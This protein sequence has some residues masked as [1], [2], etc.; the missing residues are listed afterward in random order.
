[1]AIIKKFT[2]Y[3]NLSN[4]QVL[5]DD[6]NPNSDYFR[7]TEFRETFTGGKNAFLIEGSPL[8]K[9]TTEIKIE[10]LDVEGNP[11][12]YEPGDG[13]PE[14]YE[15]L[16]KV[17][18]VHIYPDTPIGLGKITILGELKQYV[19]ELGIIRD[20][21]DEWKGAYNVK[22][23][24]N[25][26][27]NR[28]LQNESAVRFY[29]RP[30]VQ[31]TEI[32]KPIFNKT[33]P[34]K[35][36]SGSVSGEPIQPGIGTNISTWRAGT[37]YR[38]TLSSGSWDKDIDENPINISVNGNSFNPTIIEVLNDRQVL[39]DTPYS[40]N[41]LVQ[42]FSSQSFT[43]SYQDFENEIPGE[44]SLTGSFGKIDLTQ[45][46]TFAGDVARVKI[47]RRSRNEVGDFQFVQESRLE[48]TEL[49]RDIFVSDAVEIP[50]GNFSL[51]ALNTYWESSS[52]S[53]PITVDSS[54]L[55][56]AVKVDYA[57]SGVQRLF[58][59]QSFNI[60]KDV[61]YE[62]SFKTL[63][64]GSTT[65]D[66]YLRAYLTGS[67]VNSNS[68]ISQFEQNF[69]FISGSGVFSTRQ[70]VS[71]NILAERDITA[72]L[73]FEFKGDDWYL[74]Q[75]SLK[76][77]QE[78]SFSPDEFTLIQ[79]I[80]RKL[81][82]ETFDFRFEF[83][84]I[85]NNY[86]PVDVTATKEFDGGND[87]IIGGTSARI[88]T[89]E[90]DRNAF[91]YASG[92]ASPNNQT[93]LLQ[94]T[95]TNLTGSI[96]YESSA[97]DQG[98][99][100]L[101]SSGWEQ[102]PGLLTNRT[103]S[104]SGG[105]ST[106]TVA[107]FS[108]SWTG[109]GT[110]PEVYS[111]VYT[112]SVEDLQ[113]FETVFR[114]E[115]GDN[116][117]QLLVTSNANQFIY[118]PTT[119]SPKPSGQSI[120][121]RAQRKNLESLNSTITVTS[122]SNLPPLTV[123]SD[124]GGIKTYSISALEFS[125][126]FAQN[127][128]DEVTYNFSSNDVFGVAQTDE[129][130]ISKVI[131]FDGISVV[132]STENT[133]FNADSTGTVTSAELDTGD[134]TVD[135]RVGSNVISHSEGLG[136]KNTFDIVSVTPSSGL[137]AN[138]TSPITN[139]YGISAMGVD[140]GTLTLLIR[141]K[142]GDNSTTVDFTKVVNYSKA[143]KAQPS[144]T[145]SATP[146]AQTISANS[147]G[148]LIGAITDVVISG[149]EGSTSLTYNQSPTLS[150]GQYKITNVTG[151]NVSDTTPSSSTIDITAFSGDTATGTASIS[152][153]DSEGTSGT[154][155]IK[156][157]LS[158]AKRATPVIVASLNPQTQT[159]D[160]NASFSSVGTPQN[161]TLIVNEGGTNYTYTTGTV[162]ENKFKI[163][164]VTGGTNNN[165]GTITPT[166]PTDA[167]GTS[168]TITYSYTNSEG[169]PF[170]SKTIDFNVGVSV[171]GINGTSGLSAFSIEVNPPSQEVIIDIQNNITTPDT[172]SV[173]VFDAGGIYTYSELPVSASFNVTNLSQ[174]NHSGTPSNLSGTITPVVPDDVNGSEVTFDVTVTDRAGVTSDAISKTHKIRVVADGSTGPGIVFTGVW[175]TDRIYQYDISNGR[176][177]AVLWSTNGN[178]PYETYYATLQQAPADI[179]S[180]DI[181]TGSYWEY[182][183]E[184]DFFVA[185]KIA[186]FEES[187]IKN[188][189]NIGANNN[190]ALSSA[191]I[192]L[193]GKD[194]YPYFSLGQ[195]ATVG[196]QEYGVNGIFIGRHDINKNINAP[197]GSY[198]LSLVNGTSSWLKWNGSSLD[199]KGDITITNPDDF[200]PTDAEA[201]PSDYA[202]GGS[203]F[204]LRSETAATGLNLNANYLGY[205][206][207]TQFKSYMDSSGN[208]YLSGTNQ[209][210]SWDAGTDT[211]TINGEINITN[212]DD[213]APT[214]A[215]ANPS[216]Y[217]F[218][219]TGF[220]LRSE[221][222]AV[223]LN[224]NANFL[225]YHN[226]TA[227]KS[228]MDSSGN[229]YLSG[230]N[231]G[232]SWNSATD[233]LNINGSITFANSPNISTFTNDSGF[234]DDT[235]AN[236]AQTAANNA[237]TA[238]SNAQ[239]TANN[240][241]IAASN[242]QTT[243]NSRPKVF[244]QN[245][246]PSTSEPGGSLWYDTDDG[247]KLYI[248]VGTTWTVTQDG[249][250]ASAISAAS[251]ASIAAGAVS[252]DLQDVID[253]VSLS[254]AGTFIDAKT[255]FAPLIAGTT[256][257]ISGTFKVGNGGITLDGPNKKIFTGTGTWGN[258]NTPFYVDN[259]SNFSLGT[260]I[261][262][263]GTTLVV[264]GE[265]N[266][267]TGNIGGWTISPTEISGG[268]LEL[269]S[270][271]QI[272]VIDS[273]LPKL[274]I[275]SGPLSN[276][277]GGSSLSGLNFGVTDLFSWNDST[278]SAFT[279]IKWGGLYDA[280]TAPAAGTYAGTVS[281]LAA[282][283][284]FYTP[285][286][287][288]GFVTVSLVAQIASNTT[289]TN[290]IS[291]QEIS[292][293]TV[294]TA[295]TYG[296]LPAATRGMLVNIPSSGTYYARIYW[297]R[298]VSAGFGGSPVGFSQVFSVTSNNTFATSIQASELTNEGL[299][300]VASAAYY[301]RVE[302]DEGF[303]GTTPFVQVGGDL[304]A[305]GNI[306]AYYSS[307]KRLKDNITPITNPLSK[308][309][310]L[311]GYEFDWNNNHPMFK[312]THDVGVIAQEVQDIHPEIVGD[313]VGGYLGVKYEKLV[314]LL[315][316]GIKELSSKVEF[317]EN[318][319][320]ELKDGNK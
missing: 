83:Y 224:L 314:P 195:S 10:I 65:S 44:S 312:G 41:S 146:Q 217:A 71:Q 60:S 107:N 38:L 285:S 28:N 136:S 163:T 180:P 52:I 159:V 203:G 164:S 25:F 86:I 212:P 293:V 192:T 219:G 150:P 4:Y 116:A 155:T 173:Q 258:S 120:T 227:F 225:G 261:T 132:L 280:F 105:S 249:Q 286:G 281:C 298:S 201:N 189:L 7:I 127:N 307:D 210:L 282:P 260:G 54:V 171:Q 91:R 313:M 126:S 181:T 268:D 26:Q 213:F 143:K 151:V 104:I 289:F 238:A 292:T 222:A 22:W 316:E 27:I 207:G 157:T 31:I 87:Y 300:V 80:P 259:A 193:W 262:W 37:L 96:L 232:L 279:Q 130:T 108:G 175:D 119:L 271:G 244:R 140:S 92:S 184:E 94:V 133:S 263:N 187:F 220:A 20:V 272:N 13:I 48:S 269:K 161:I 29:K 158:K 267:I 78:T 188:T 58:T 139:S 190:G 109:S 106:L 199:I 294:G 230:T 123:V 6:I 168:G 252:D 264:S 216:D 97:F 251:A 206:N 250:I 113:E 131:N 178:P 247:N 53:H 36:V 11:V 137:T 176:R 17:V 135:V 81:E 115:D 15:G 226:G 39:V 19:D 118:E 318:E 236:N 98:G 240:A 101:T 204:A 147:I 278:T 23:E 304:S 299:Q 1:M 169:T 265:I 174:T 275:R 149:F 51:N 308:L 50:Y 5:V 102:Y 288:T 196:T 124:T 284:I 8:L 166:T 21:S 182:L 276:I 144:I 100:F 148:T 245:S 46:K 117:P 89:F 112:A 221:T 88:L 122:G 194:E 306:I 295:L 234:T 243:A 179:D 229:F 64:S 55:S 291:T 49:L 202:F 233:T 138:S 3:Q 99:N 67:F 95:K 231:Q 191:N 287:F 77:A 209:G 162:T 197:D 319:I 63:L 200:A 84:D 43:S 297:Q 235:A 75:V 110:Q 24:K 93:I 309:S 40:E 125:S 142:A 32:V 218:G 214:D 61:E 69:V 90:S 103:D 129:I 273:G 14:Y 76:N 56:Q 66:K 47:Y 311:G 183:G 72:S 185:A 315:I 170:T 296:S 114:I 12:Y 160:S 121:I 172:F 85:N 165:D 246:A 270:S 205:H 211:L 254:G 317:L 42:P 320:K 62:L 128:F 228:Y 156:F 70:N 186:I 45:L 310:K 167:T 242:A 152:Y 154:Q 198:V 134:G 208:F 215:E 79:P 256:G 290:I 57:G 257:Y 303:T 255:I 241:A 302:R 223:G 59:S 237:A 145:F 283:N 277:T 153:K 34:T 18:S 82:K 141:Y 74:S 2:S 68:Q 33:I 111:I 9:E 35:T 266:A 16:S 248:L 253:G 73:A 274:V 239:T 177:D 305:T 30:Q 301:M